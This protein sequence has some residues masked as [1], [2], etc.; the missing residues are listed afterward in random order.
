MPLHLAH[1]QQWPRY[2]IDALKEGLW[3]TNISGLPFRSIALD[4][5]HE[6]MINRD[7]KMSLSRAPGPENVLLK[8]NTLNLRSRTL[9]I[10]KEQIDLGTRN[11]NQ[12]KPG[13]GQNPHK[14]LEIHVQNAQMMLLSS[15][16]LEGKPIDGQDQLWHLF[17]EEFAS[18]Q[19][20]L[21][22]LTCRETG[23][24]LVTSYIAHSILRQPSSKQQ[25]LKKQLLKGFEPLKPKAQSKGPGKNCSKEKPLNNEEASRSGA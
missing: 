23:E 9:K 3:T 25:P 24:R 7:L 2:V 8:T 6:Q 1:L 19:S 12:S 17:K 5:A 10:L 20:E 14:H 16:R 4:E 22:L 13:H 21:D 15:K 11:N 18:L